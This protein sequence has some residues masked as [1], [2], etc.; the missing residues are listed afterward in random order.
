MKPRI[1]PKRSALT[2][3]ST[4]PAMTRTVYATAANQG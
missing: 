2:M 4:R 3:V 1:S